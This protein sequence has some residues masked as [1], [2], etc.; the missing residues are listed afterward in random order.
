M[1]ASMEQ[2][3]VL[4]CRH[5]TK[6]GYWL[7]AC[8]IG[9]FLVAGMQQRLVLGC[10]TSQQPAKSTPGI[11]LYKQLNRRQTVDQTCS[12]TWS[13]YIDTGPTSPSIEST[14]PGFCQGRHVRTS[15]KALVG[16]EQ[17]KEGNT[18][19]YTVKRRNKFLL[20][21]LQCCQTDGSR[22]R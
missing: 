14:A 1:V 4:G 15:F 2:R 3:L 17:G 12:L 22:A 7:P 9:Y 5:G 16:L 11:N 20:L 6:I 8:S 13:Q 21:T 10:L 19:A 18:A